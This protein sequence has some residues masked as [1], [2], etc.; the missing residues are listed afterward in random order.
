MVDK[1]TGKYIKSVDERDLSDFIPLITKNKADE[2]KVVL[3]AY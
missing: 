2:S 1:T 3:Y